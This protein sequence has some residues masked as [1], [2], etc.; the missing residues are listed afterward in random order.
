MLDR[1]NVE[2]ARHDTEGV[3]VEPYLKAALDSIIDDLMAGQKARGL[4]WGL[5]DFL[6]DQ[7][8]LHEL[9]SAATI[10]RDWT[11]LEA[12]I[13]RRLRAQLADHDAVA[14]RAMELDEDARSGA[15]E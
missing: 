10:S 1:N 15:D 13:D 2:E 6:A 8:D 11:A 5:Q 9:V 3:D 12:E 4:R 7:A 14:E